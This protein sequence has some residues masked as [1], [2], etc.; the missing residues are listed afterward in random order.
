MPTVNPL[1]NFRSYSYKHILIA[2]D[3]SLVAEHIS[4]LSGEDIFNEIITQKGAGSRSSNEEGSDADGILVKDVTGFGKYAIII[5][6]FSDSEFF[7]SKAEWETLMAPHYGSKTKN[8]DFVTTVATEGELTVVEPRG[9][10]FLNVVNNTGNALGCGSVAITWL[11]KTIFVGQSDTGQP[12]YISNIKP[13]VF[14]LMNVTAAFDEGGSVYQ[15]PIVAAS[16]GIA[17]APHYSRINVNSINLSIN[18][19]LET[20]MAKMETLLNN[21]YA[22]KIQELRDKGFV[23]LSNETQRELRYVINL[24]DTYTGSDFVM[25]KFTMPQTGEGDITGGTI[26]FGDNVDVEY[27]LRQ[28]MMR[29]SKVINAAK[30]SPSKIFKIYTI[31]S[32]DEN[33]GYVTYNIK[34]QCVPEAVDQDKLVTGLPFDV[35]EFDYIYTGLNIDIVDFQIR[36]EQ[37]MA[38]FQSLQVMETAV[39]DQ[40]A[41]NKAPESDSSRSIDGPDKVV[42]SSF[43]M[44][45]I[46]NERKLSRSVKDPL[47]TQEFNTALSKYST[48]ETLEASMTI[49]GNPLLLNDMNLLPRDY[50]PGQTG[51]GSSSTRLL[52]NWQTAPSLCKVNISMPSNNSLLGIGPEN[53]FQTPFWYRG[54]YSILSINHKFDNAIFNQTL[55]MVNVRISEDPVAPPEYKDK[56]QTDVQET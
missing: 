8:K 48:M 50:A 42:M 54:Y 7:I 28:I 37:G 23:E 10:R 55:N 2:C 56:L 11:L 38:F 15:M 46:P 24:D 51:G 47:S 36:M 27:M 52:P 29:C 43:I 12:E 9:F 13:F 41:Q 5:N 14:N 19:T 21:T 25:D 32:S 16:N 1:H 33:Y 17:K 22:N 18:D 6:S 31:F 40:R 53:Q 4:D 34:Q 30:E 35:L 39:D 26:T 20:S 49:H 3:T 45:V 44:P